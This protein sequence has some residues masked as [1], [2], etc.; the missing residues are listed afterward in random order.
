MLVATLRCFADWA[1]WIILIIQ[2]PLTHNVKFRL[3][4][5]YLL[6]DIRSVSSSLSET[7]ASNVIS[8]SNLT[9]EGFTPDNPYIVR[10]SKAIEV[11][12][13]VNPPVSNKSK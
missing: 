5:C 7:L 11:L 10:N 6:I 8:E 3:M 1:M 4:S 12:E 13:R 2:I 9:F